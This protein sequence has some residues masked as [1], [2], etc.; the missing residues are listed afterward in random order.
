MELIKKADIKIQLLKHSIFNGNFMVFEKSNQI[1]NKSVLGLSRPII[2]DSFILSDKQLIYMLF[3]YCELPMIPKWQLIYRASQDGF[4]AASFHSKCDNKP[5]TLIIIKT[6]SGNIFGGYT[7]QSWLSTDSYKTDP[8]AF[9]FSIKNAY[10]HSIKM[11][12]SNNFSIC[13]SNS[14]G[15]T[16][17]LGHDL[18]IADKSNTNMNSYSNICN[19][20]IHNRLVYG[21]DEAKSFLAGSVN[22]NVNEIEVYTN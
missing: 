10:Q 12:C 7:E 6:E 22:F 21:S 18:H 5:N 11:N 13:C 2:I 14:Y 4:E 9:I 8:K 16:F 17:G 3:S 15:P 19:S 20:Y 1:I